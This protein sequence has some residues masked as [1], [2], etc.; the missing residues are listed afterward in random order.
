MTKPAMEPPPGK[1]SSFD[2]PDREMYYIFKIGFM[3]YC[4]ICLLMLRY[5]GGLH[6][7]DVPEHLLP[8]YN[9]TVYATMVNY[10]PTVLA[11]KAAI[12]LFLARIF[13]PYKVYV[14]WIYGFLGVM[15]AYYII[16]LFLK[17]FICRP[18]SIFWG[19]PVDGECFNQRVLIL[20][21]NIISLLSDLVV[22]LLPC[23]LT[24]KLQVGLAAKLKIAAVFGMGGVACIF[25]LV[26]LVIIVQH[27]ESPDQTYTFVKINLLGIAECGIGVV[28][29]CLPFLPM[30][31]KSILHKD[32]PGYSSNYAK[33]QFEMM[34]SSNKRS[35]H[36]T[37]TPASIHF[38][39]DLGSDEN[40]LISNGRSQVTTNV[41][42]GHDAAARKGRVGASLDDSS[43]LRTVEVHHSGF[44][45][46]HSLVS[47]FPSSIVLHVHQNRSLLVHMDGR[48]MTLVSDDTLVHPAKRQRTT[49]QRFENDPLYDRYTVAWICA[50][51]IEMAAARAM[52]DETHDHL[53]QPINDSNSYILGRMQKHNVVIACL[54]AGQYGTVNAASVLTNMKS[55]F[56]KIRIG[57]MV[58]VGGGVPT[59]AD[60]R[61]GDIVVGI[62]IMQSDLGKTVNGKLQRTAVPKI[63]DSSIRTVIS[64][65]RSRH[66]LSSS[67]VPLILSDKMSAHPS[68]CFP[69][70][71]DRLFLSSY[72]HESLAST[73]DKCDLS[74]LEAREI[75]ASSDPIIHYGGIA[76]SS[77]VMKDAASRD[78]IAR[79]LDVICFEMEAA[80]LMDVMPCLPI[81]GICDYA[82]SHKSKEWQ[83]YA[84]ATAAAYAYELLEVWGGDAQSIQV[85]YSLPQNE[86]CVST[87]RHEKIMDLLNFEQIDSRKTTIK[88]A[89]SKTCQWFLKHPDYLAWTNPQQIAQHHGFLWIRGKPGAGKSTIMKFIYLK[90]KRK[91][92]KSR[93]LTASFF[94]NARGGQLEKTVSGMYRSLLL[95]LFKGY[96]DLQCVLEDPE[97]L[98]PGQTSCPSL[99]ILKD[100][101]R[102]AISKLNQ[103]SFTCFIDALDECD[104]QQ[105]MDLVEYFEDLAEQCTEDGVRLQICFSSRH[106]PFIDIKFGL[107]L[108]LE[109]QIGHVSDLETYIKTHLRIRDQALLQEL[110]AKMLEKAAGVFLWVVLVVDMLN[111]ENRRG[112]LSLKRRLEEVPSGLSE[113]FKDLLRRDKTN[114]EELLLSLLWILLSKRPLKPEEYYH[115]L[116][117]G[118][119]L[120]GLADPDLPELT[121]T[122]SN[123]C[124]DRCVISSSKGL[125]EITKSKNPT[126]QFIHESVRDFLVKDKGLHELW[127]ELGADW[128]SVGHERL[129]LCCNYYTQLDV[130]QGLESMGLQE[131][132]NKFPFLEYASQFVLHHAE[133]AGNAICQ[134]EFLDRFGTQSWTS[135]F[136]IFEK[137]KTRRYTPDAKLIYI[138]AE[139]G[140]S[141]LIR[142][143]LRSDP[144]IDVP[145]DGERYRYPLIAAMAKGHKSSVVALL[146]LS[147]AVHDGVDI[148]ENLVC[149]IDAGGKL[150]TPF[151]WACE[152]GH[153]GIAK[154][155][156]QRGVHGDEKRRHGSTSLML[157][158]KK[159]YTDIV[160]LLSNDRPSIHATF[161]QE[162]AI[163]LAF[164]NG[165]TEILEIL[166]DAG[167]DSNSYDATGSS[168]LCLA[169]ST[170]NEVAVRLLL[171]NGAYVD[172][173]DALGRRPLHF[174]AR[175]TGS[176]TIMKE[177]IRYGADIDAQ[178][179]YGDTCL[180]TVASHANLREIDL[181][182]KN[183]ADVN[184][185]NH[186][187]QTCLHRVLENRVDTFRAVQ[188]FI[189]NGVDIHARDHQGNTCLM[190]AARFATS[191]EIELLIKNGADVNTRNRA[192]ETC[193]HQIMS[194]TPYVDSPLEIFLEKGV[195]VN[196]RNQ[197][198]ETC[199]HWLG[200]ARTILP[201]VDDLFQLLNRYAVDFNARDNHG[202][203]PLHAMLERIS[204]STVLEDLVKQPGLDLNARNDEGKTPLHIASRTR[205]STISAMLIERRVD[206]NSIDDEGATPLDEA[207]A[208]GRAEL[209]QFLIQNGGRRGSAI[210][211]I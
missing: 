1:E 38:N 78:E 59:K 22:L 8:R 39:D 148:T 64:N 70:E 193:L 159:G 162:T 90:A 10:G 143:R 101:L 211:A 91:D 26:R 200:R 74:K 94:F 179:E 172:A 92:I 185:R 189:D 167:A 47:N 155:L 160:R 67:R 199:L 33:S 14:R 24:K 18:I 128:E 191:R 37:Q 109:E 48:R 80:G 27:G 3:G 192:G 49:A 161:K 178:D 15:S 86:H 44:S 50:L 63:P 145:V 121:T 31:W 98:P 122:D 206:I 182:I 156:I 175:L 12:L 201:L 76:S 83:R 205:N 60:I 149:N 11:I 43:I 17:T 142:T 96:P 127:P 207:M 125:A 54:P 81:R 174:A 137:F 41:R 85:D 77:Q 25:G 23:P 114:M 93:T 151:S 118:L 187:G 183:G 138:L 36:T 196:A 146:G 55:T 2:N 113:L 75:R 19:D 180:M 126:V 16:M 130:V 194:Y 150:H 176:E 184:A 131:I 133:H 197:I 61:L 6:Q 34:N 136:N 123:D 65:L 87:G 134:Q 112:R 97:L 102:S 144:D 4:T 110:Q 40:V 210:Q 132:E 30:L 154:L 195:D 69:D 56:P 88:A 168:L 32:K 53:P 177:L 190:A 129:K 158:A 152:H 58:G 204:N 29:A 9:Q 157:A 20:V 35:R 21:D 165:H 106:Y 202:N 135:I 45:G 104:E 169:T 42:A 13:S 5:G 153:P 111:G 115:A 170:I 100:L 166:L 186:A 52:L 203:T 62:R 116:W 66:E 198:G 208:A 117:S 95:Q 79:E 84:A 181:L 89:H 171:E 57:L 141:I 51:H 68:Y 46:A 105:V 103:R 107:R 119:S 72:H 71:P 28:C 173:A 147:S 7:W 164:S 139:R 209:A 163:W 140:H 99:N 82:D 73:C 124:L 188:V 108:I 120:E